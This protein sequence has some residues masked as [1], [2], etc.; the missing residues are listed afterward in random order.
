LAIALGN[1]PPNP[2]IY[3]SLVTKRTQISDNLLLE[4][5]DWALAQ[6]HFA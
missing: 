6:Q 2:K 1:A 5:I 4:H 3:Q